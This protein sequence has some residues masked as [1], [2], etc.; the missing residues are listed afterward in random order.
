MQPRGAGYGCRQE[1]DA[2]LGSHHVVC[3]MQKKANKKAVKA[4]ALNRPNPRG[5]PPPSI[6]IIPMSCR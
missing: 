4:A 5:P 6:Q 2:C 1:C 3:P